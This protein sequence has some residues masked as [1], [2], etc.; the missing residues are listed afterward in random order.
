M[1]EAIKPKLR[2]RPFAIIIRDGWGY[3]EDPAMHA[4]D[5]T[6]VANTPTADRLNREYS[7]TLIRTSGEDVGLPPGTMGNS[8]VGHQNIGAGR[9]VFQES[10]RLTNEIRQ[11]TFFE[12]EELLKAIDNAKKNQS[13]IHFIGLASDIGVHSLLGHLYGLLEMCKRNDLDRVFV[14]PLMDGRDSPPTSGKGYLTDIQSKM[15]EMGVGQFA[16]VM[17][18]F[19]GM[20]RDQRWDRVEK[21]YQCMRNGKGERAS[22]AIEAIQASYD[23]QI[24]DE[25]VEPTNITDANGNPI[26]LVEDG[27]S[28]VFF[29]FRGDRPR[30]IT[31][32]FVDPEFSAFDRGA[33]PQL[34]YVCLTEYDKTIPAPVAFKKPPKMKNIVGEYWSKLGLKQFR[35]AETE[36]YAHV[37]FFFNDYTE[38]PFPGEDRQI[39]PSPKV[40]T[41]DEKP[42]MSAYEVCDQVLKRLDSNEYDVMVINFANPDMVGHTGDMQAAIKAAETV[43]TCVGRIIE[44]IEAMGG[45]AVVL[46]DHGNLELMWDVT[47]NGPHTAH[48]TYPVPFIVVDK[49]L[50]VCKLREDGRLADVIPTCLDIMGVSQPEEMTGKTIIIH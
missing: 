42:E 37:T 49:E 3:N 18:R 40:R 14:H 22:N 38:P 29:N 24:T 10:M 23:H 5:A 27:D 15:D 2:T 16:S 20:D 21:A 31:R 50:K 32:A 19:Y 13:K 12:N 4:Y 36:K 47:T 6:R 28:V 1:P 39:V 26:A 8:E 34:Y 44:K 11:G 41:Y 30:E 35:C 9:I 45:S 33:L 7:W 43:D 17:G 48:T 25:F 46:A